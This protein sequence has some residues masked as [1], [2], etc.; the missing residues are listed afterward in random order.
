[1]A[2]DSKHSEHLS[3]LGA[4]ARPRGEGAS[5]PWLVCMS[6]RA[7]Q[8]Q[9]CAIL[10]RAEAGGCQA[11]VVRQ[12][13]Q[14]VV[15][16]AERAGAE[17]TL[18]GLANCAGVESAVESSSPFALSSRE[19][20]RDT[21]VVAAGDARVGGPEPVVIVG[22]RADEEPE[23]LRAALKIKEAGAHM[24]YGRARRPLSAECLRGLS[25]AARA[26]GLALVLEVAA[27]AEVAAAVEVADVLQVGPSAMQDYSLLSRLGAARR[28]VIL[29]RNHGATVEE[30][31]LA[32]EYLLAGGNP[33]VVL[34]ECGIRT[35]A[36]SPP[37]TLDLA[38]VVQV[39]ESSHLPIIVDVTQEADAPL[40]QSS[41]LA[42]AAAAAG[43]D[44]F[45]IDF[46]PWDTPEGFR[47]PRLKDIARLVRELREP[48][49]LMPA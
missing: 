16:V 35:F 45:V 4:A 21:T 47:P 48:A 20:R 15:I 49:P 19:W 41:A 8:E 25:E 13:G 17:R 12:R 10:L 5:G 14:T 32:A 40:A 31:L 2:Y 24:L 18:E 37:Y 36:A 9:V 11:R 44:G 27:A 3:S 1:M 23:L 38:A 34:C 22:L 28:P 6:A 33:D 26:A 39:Q 7:T 30:W 46:K 42:R 29:K 43:A